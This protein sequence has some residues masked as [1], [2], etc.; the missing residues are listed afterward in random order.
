MRVIA[1]ASGNK[2]QSPALSSTSKRNTFIH[3]IF[4]ISRYGPP[5][6][7]Q[8][9][10][11]HTSTLSGREVLYPPTRQ[12]RWL[13]P[14]AAASISQADHPQLLGALHEVKHRRK[15]QAYQMSSKIYSLKQPHRN[16]RGQTRIENP[17]RNER[18]LPPHK[19]RL[20]ILHENRRGLGRQC[21]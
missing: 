12:L 17:Q 13:E 18:L 21:R 10:L 9:S 6:L 15:M 3:L 2:P 1:T 20:L 4:F 5:L 16:L 8:Y 14:K 11:P 7:Q 19:Y